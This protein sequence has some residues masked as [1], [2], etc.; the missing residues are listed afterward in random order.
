M[1]CKQW[2]Y[3]HKTTRK[4]DKTGGKSIQKL[5]SSIISFDISLLGKQICIGCV[6]STNS[7][8]AWHLPMIFNSWK[9]L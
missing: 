8:I 3:D 4:T 6:Y 7:T 5:I 2:K 1:C 9:L